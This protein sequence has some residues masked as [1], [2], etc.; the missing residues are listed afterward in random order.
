MLKRHQLAV[1]V[2]AC[3]AVLVVGAQPAISNTFDD[4]PPGFWARS[5]IDRITTA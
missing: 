5:I 2:M 4:V 3:V 1:T